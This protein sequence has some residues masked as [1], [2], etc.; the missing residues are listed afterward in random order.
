M[1]F[2][3]SLGSAVINA[4]TAA[5][6]GGSGIPSL[7]GYTIGDKV[8]NY[9][10]KSIWSLYEGI[11]KVSFKFKQTFVDFKLLFVVSCIFFFR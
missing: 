10:G 9:E 3:S 5:L 7:P 4:S 1:N 8:L 11:K 2:L 6:S